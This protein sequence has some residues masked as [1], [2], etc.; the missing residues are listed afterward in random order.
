MSSAEDMTIQDSSVS[1]RA[2]SGEDALNRRLADYIPEYM[3]PTED[4]RIEPQP[5][6]T[7]NR[8]KNQRT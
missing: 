2:D 8:Q 7:K 1:N 6:R 5:K 3:N 4:E